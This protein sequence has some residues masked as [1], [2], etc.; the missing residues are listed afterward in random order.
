MLDCFALNVFTLFDDGRCSAEVGICGRHIVEA[1]VIAPMIVVLDAG[2]DLAFEVTGQE[3]VLYKDRVLQRLM[4]AL[5]LALCLGMKW[6]ASDMIHAIF[7][8][9]V[10]GAAVA[11][12]ARSV[13]YMRLIAA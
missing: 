8:G 7:L 2:L 1:V 6:R 3:V 10:T 11:Q 4:R 13:R 9:D 5:D 12:Q